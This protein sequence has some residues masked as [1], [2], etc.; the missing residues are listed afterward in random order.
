M[1]VAAAVAV[2]MRIVVAAVVLAM[3][4]EVAAVVVVGRGMS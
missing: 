3:V 4:V 2:A 1:T